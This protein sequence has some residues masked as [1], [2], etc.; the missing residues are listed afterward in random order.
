MHDG[1][2][3]ALPRDQEKVETTSTNYRDKLQFVNSMK[4]LIFDLTKIPL[5]ECS[6]IIYCLIA[7]VFHDQNLFTELNLGDWFSSCVQF[8]SGD[9]FSKRAEAAW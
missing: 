4:R 9:H 3:Q 6:I 7:E 8:C 2:T 5:L 1:A